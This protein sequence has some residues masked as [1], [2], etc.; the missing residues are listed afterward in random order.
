[1]KYAANDKAYYLELDDFLLS[2]ELVAIIKMMIGCRAFGKMEILE[3]VSKLKHFTSC[4]D[5]AM[6]EKII[7]K[8]MYHYHEVR[9]DCKS[10]IQNLWQLVRCIH[11]KTE[12]SVRYYKITRELV[13]RRLRPAAITF[14]DYY[15]YLIAFRCDEEG[16]SLYTTVWTGS[17][18]SWSTGSISSRIAHMTLMRENCGARYSS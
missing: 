10:V 5:R 3:I 18:R 14:S 2:K 4:N 15:F 6:L 7:R 11:G 12:I 17:S 16:G 9:H 1:M 8:E 13:I